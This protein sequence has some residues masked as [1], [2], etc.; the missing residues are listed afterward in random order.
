[1]KP[2]VT[3]QKYEQGDRGIPAEELPAIDPGPSGLGKPSLPQEGLFG[4]DR[5]D[6]SSR[7]LS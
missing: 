3:K 6:P 7:G 5:S 1:M 2:L 4:F